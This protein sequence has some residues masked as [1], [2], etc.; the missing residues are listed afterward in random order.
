M[1]KAD[2]C[3]TEWVEKGKAPEV[4]DAATVSMDPTAAVK[5]R[6]LCQYPKVAAYIGG[7]PDEASSYQCADSFGTKKARNEWPTH[8]EL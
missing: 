4:L 2:K 3:F 8:T 6:P 1:L 5:T 7:N